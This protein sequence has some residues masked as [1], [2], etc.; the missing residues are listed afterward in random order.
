MDFY[1]FIGLDLEAMSSYM[2]LAGIQGNIYHGENPLFSRVNFNHYAHVRVEKRRE[3]EAKPPLDQMKVL[4]CA[5]VPPPPPSE[6]K[7]SGRLPAGHW[8]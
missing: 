5:G 3:K 6:I 7:F 4:V 8:H 2:G 1:I